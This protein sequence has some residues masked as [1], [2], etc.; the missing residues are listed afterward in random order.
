M[1]LEKILR[2]CLSYVARINPLPLYLP[3]HKLLLGIS[4]VHMLCCIGDSLHFKALVGWC[5]VRRPSLV[6]IDFV[7][8]QQPAAN[9]KVSWR[10]EIASD[11][12]D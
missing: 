2:H 12:I 1:E 9:P 8:S 7:P 5:A 10:N 6:R 4:P 3:H 11:G